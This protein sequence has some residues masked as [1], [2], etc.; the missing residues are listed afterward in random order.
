MLT[1]MHGVSH[2]LSK[3]GLGD[4]TTA[5]LHQQERADAHLY[6]GRCVLACMQFLIVFN[7]RSLYHILWG[8]SSFKIGTTCTPLSSDRW[9]QRAV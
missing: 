2:G 1:T 8:G 9:N 5:L 7:S 6:Y 3:S 4:F